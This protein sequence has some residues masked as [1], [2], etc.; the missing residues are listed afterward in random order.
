MNIL[1]GT[2]GKGLVGLSNLS[3]EF[4]DADMNFSSTEN[5]QASGHSNVTAR[6]DSH[7]LITSDNTHRLYT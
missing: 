3:K 7:A 5:I 2:S 4:L 1:L 6:D